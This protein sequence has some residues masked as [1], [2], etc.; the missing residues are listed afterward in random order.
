MRALVLCYGTMTQ[1][2]IKLPYFV[3]IYVK[4]TDFCEYNLFCKS[5]ACKRVKGKTGLVRVTS[6]EEGKLNSNFPT[7][8]MGQYKA[9]YSLYL[10]DLGEGS[11]L[12]GD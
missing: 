9:L 10:T 1:L 7:N 5:S 11:S 3:Y 2:L 12:S 4:L 8:S 6:L